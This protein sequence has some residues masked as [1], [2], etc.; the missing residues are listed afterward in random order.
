MDWK[1]KR[2][3]RLNEWYDVQCN[4][5]GHN[6]NHLFAYAKWEMTHIRRAMKALIKFFHKGEFTNS[7]QF[8]KTVEFQHLLC[9]LREE[10]WNPNMFQCSLE[11][12]AT[13]F[14]RPRLSFALNATPRMCLMHRR[15]AN[16]TCHLYT[17]IYLNRSYNVV[18]VEHRVYFYLKKK[19]KLT[20]PKINDIK[21]ARIRI[22]L[23]NVWNLWPI[24]CPF[25]GEF[26]RCL[27]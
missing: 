18:E 16:V 10:H 11:F 13:N 20:L 19:M 23:E 8:G 3:F 24:A 6:E 25:I 9:L 12:L 17:Y 22:I 1:S 15:K 4:A 27:R 14:S 26:H 7:T 2:C 21:I 5:N